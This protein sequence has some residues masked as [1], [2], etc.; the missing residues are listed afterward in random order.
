MRTLIRF[1]S[2]SAPAR[3]EVAVN[4]LYSIAIPIIVASSGAIPAIP[5]LGPAEPLTSGIVAA[6]DGTI[7]F[8][9]SF[10]ETVWRLQPGSPLDA[11][12]SGRNG[13]A[14]C[15]DADGH[16]YGTHE[17]ESGRI[18]MWRADGS[19]N[20]IHLSHPDVPQYGHAFVVEDDGEMIAS[21]GTGRRTGVRLLRASEHDHEVLAGG[22][23]GFRD[24]AGA[25]ARF[26]PIGGMTRT[27]EGDLLV[28]SGAAIR[29]VRADGTVMTIAKGER[30]LKPR[31]AFLARLFGNVYGHLTGIA[32]GLHGEIYVANSARNA[33]IRINANGSADELVKSDGGWTPTGVATANG[34]LYI[35]E[36]GRGVRVRRID[37]SGTL[38]IVAQVKPDRAVAAAVPHGRFV[39]PGTI[40]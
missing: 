40:G 11:F 38:S 7:F 4:R 21:S 15:L 28:T 31:H 9:D 34:S 32:V 26:F 16:L 8:V 35:L 19:G 27:P 36:Y 18:A 22:D 13:R 3:R 37:A 17:D 5:T 23:L 12:V 10:S 33:V 20:V 14:L 30:L 1:L 24:G 29:R 39:V 6:D 25:E 2:P